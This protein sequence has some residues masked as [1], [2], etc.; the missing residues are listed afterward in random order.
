[1]SYLFAIAAK[2]KSAQIVW[3]DNIVYNADAYNTTDWDNPTNGIA[4]GWGGTYN[5]ASIV[6][7]NGFSGNAQR[8]TRNAG[9]SNFALIQNEAAFLAVSP[10]AQYKL[11]LKFRCEDSRNQGLDAWVDTDD[12]YFFLKRFGENTGNALYDEVIFEVTGRIK[13]I[14]FGFWDNN[15][16]LPSGTYW[17][18]IDEIELKPEL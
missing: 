11:S 3:D 17:F 7:G 6:T 15:L 5:S 1:M 4:D 18:E 14:V 10:I 9:A 2:K 16:N 13:N 12:D 8:L